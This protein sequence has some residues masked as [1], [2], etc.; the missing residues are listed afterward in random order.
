MLD[1]AGVQRCRVA[2][3]EDL[4]R[5]CTS[6]KL[7]LRDPKTEEKLF[8]HLYLYGR[9]GFDITFHG[10]DSISMVKS[11]MASMLKLLTY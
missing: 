8:P 9:G 4:N 1:K 2:R 5:L 7:S 11:H 6:Y 10:T 3:D